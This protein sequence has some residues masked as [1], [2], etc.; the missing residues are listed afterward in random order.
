LTQIGESITSL[1]SFLDL[2]A[3]FIIGNQAQ[4]PSRRDHHPTSHLRLP[5]LVRAYGVPFPSVVDSGDLIK[6]L[7]LRTRGLPPKHDH[8]QRHRRLMVHRR[9]HPGKV[10]T[11]NFTCHRWYL[12]IANSHG[13]SRRRIHIT[14]TSATAA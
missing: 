12:T 8:Q 3:Q 7:S 4:V 2:L 9:G 13:A 6:S 14:S 10:H 11:P 1:H 5:D